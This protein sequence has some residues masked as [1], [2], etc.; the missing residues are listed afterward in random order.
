MKLVVFLSVEFFSMLLRSLIIFPS[1]LV[2]LDF[3][4]LRMAG[5]IAE[6]C[7]YACF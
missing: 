5:P 1:R 7:L 6:Y 3:E 2:G 4:N